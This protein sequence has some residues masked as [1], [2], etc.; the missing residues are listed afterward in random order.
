MMRNL[1]KLFSQA[2]GSTHENHIRNVEKYQNAQTIKPQA[3]Q[4]INIF[5]VSMIPWETFSAFNLNIISNGIHLLPIFTMGKTFQQ[6]GKTLIP[7]VI[8]VYHA[9]CDGFHVHQFLNALRR[10]ISSWQ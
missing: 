7:L 6:Q 5:D 8:Q 10:N 3:S 4:P 1:N 2:F 9:V